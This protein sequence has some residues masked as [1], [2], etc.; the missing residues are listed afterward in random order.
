MASDGDEPTEEWT[1]AERASQELNV[2]AFTADLESRYMAVKHE[3]ETLEEERA[4]DQ[5]LLTELQA[6]VKSQ[7]ESLMT[8]E[9]EL[10]TA[11][12]ESNTLREENENRLAAEKTQQERMNRMEAEA[13]NL[14]EEIRLVAYWMPL[15]NTRA[16]NDYL[17]SLC[18]LSIIVLFSSTVV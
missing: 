3:K 10:A 15:D 13:D 1:E 8:L 6:K 4:K 7:Q 17:C 16:S 2:D 9:T 11:K 18:L 12:R 5:S 14:R